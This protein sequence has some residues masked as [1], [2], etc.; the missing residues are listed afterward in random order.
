MFVKGR[1]FQVLVGRNSRLNPSKDRYQHIYDTYDD[2]STIDLLSC[3]AHGVVGPLSHGGITG[4]VTCN[5]EAVFPKVAAF[6]G[7]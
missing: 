7:Q 6:V 2:E 4:L 3:K 1:Y 5:F